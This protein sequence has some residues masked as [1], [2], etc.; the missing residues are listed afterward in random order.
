[1]RVEVMRKKVDVK[2]RLGWKVVSVNNEKKKK[3]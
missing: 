3:S 1:V 2:K